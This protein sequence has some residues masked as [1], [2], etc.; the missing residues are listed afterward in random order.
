MSLIFRQSRVLLV[1]LSQH[2]V[3]FVNVYVW[4]FL[5]AEDFSYFNQFL[6]R[7]GQF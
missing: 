4:F 6:L 1:N 2:N 3:K 7:F 5:Y